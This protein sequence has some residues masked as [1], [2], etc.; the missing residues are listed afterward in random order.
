MSM[1][2]SA[3]E[4]PET[5]LCHHCHKFYGTQTTD[6]LCSACYK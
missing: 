4:A 5:A 2:K 3:T 1:Q 6:W